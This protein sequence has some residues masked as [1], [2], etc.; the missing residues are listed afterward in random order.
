MNALKNLLT[1]SLLCF[2]A[3]CGMNNVPNEDGAQDEMDASVDALSTHGKFETFV[4]KDGDTYFHLLAGNGEKVLAS[5]GYSSLEGAQAGI[6]SVKANGTDPSKFLLRE[7]SDGAW[8]FVVTAAN[9]EIIGVSEMYASQ[10][11]ATRG[12]TTV[13]AVV[14]ATV[15]QGPATTGIAKFEIFKGLD[16]KYYFDVRALNGEI[17]LQSQSYT[18]HAGAKS[19]AASVQLNGT[20]ATKYSVQPAADGSFYFVLKAANGAIIARSETYV[21]RSNAQRAVEGC[22]VLLSTQVQQPN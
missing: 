6:A 8:Y 15:A 7:A 3:A 20:D 5:Q 11:N 2:A 10:S 13:A 12:M 4:G 1:T 18:S 21:S 16:S 9:G 19:G 14:K 17:V 22:V